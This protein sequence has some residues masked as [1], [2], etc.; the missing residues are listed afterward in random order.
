MIEGDLGGMVDIVE[1]MA[2]GHGR[3]Q[4]Y[5]CYAEQINRIDTIDPKWTK[6]ARIGFN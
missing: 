1:N 2:N 3:H 6:L 4:R 5:I